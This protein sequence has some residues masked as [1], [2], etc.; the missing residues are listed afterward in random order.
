MTDGRLRILHT[1]CT[2]EFAGVEQFIVRLA[3]AQ[4]AAGH[5]VSV[6]G[7]DPARMRPALSAA[8][9]AF[10][11]LSSTVEASRAVRAR[12]DDV[13]V[14]NSHMTAADAAVIL[15]VVGRSRR[16]ALVSTRHFAKRRGRLAPMGLV[17]DPWFDAEISISRYVASAIG[18]PSTVVHPG[19][20][21]RTERDP[22]SRE[23]VVLMAQRLQPEKQSLLGIRA[24]AASGLAEDGWMLEVA[25]DGPDRDRAG[26]LAHNLGVASA[27]RFLGFRDDVPDLMLR[28][29]ILLATCPIE[30]FGLTVLEAMAS[31]LPIVAPKSGGPAEMLEG[32]DPRALFAVDD[33]RAAGAQLRSLAADAAARRA[34]G[35]A[36]LMRQRERF[37]ADA[38][39]RHT[40]AVYRT[41]RR[42]TTAE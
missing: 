13:D 12:I 18:V 39:A 6:A 33:E 23:R 26:R 35:H 41:A 15:A 38:Q 10:A 25:G 42:T 3:V 9:V 40:E 19:V 27:T 5:E 34:Y 17:L 16:P 32:L 7:G 36:A 31:G 1:V 11:A 14:V 28:S 22:S 20:S 30:G 29:S 21:A 24:F 2:D 37:T 8:G 4:A